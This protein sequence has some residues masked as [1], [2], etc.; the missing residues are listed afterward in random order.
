MEDPSK[1]R[2]GTFIGNTKTLISF[3]T[4][5]PRASLVPHLQAL[6]LIISLPRTRSTWNEGEVQTVHPLA[7]Q[8]T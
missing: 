1:S 5:S 6:V 8:K 2:L 3:Q 7:Q 4:R